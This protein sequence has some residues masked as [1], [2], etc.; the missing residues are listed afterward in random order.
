MSIK[1]PCTDIQISTANSVCYASYSL[2]AAQVCK[3]A[4]TSL[5]IWVSALLSSFNDKR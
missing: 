3:C 5:E 2:A 4:V 1:P